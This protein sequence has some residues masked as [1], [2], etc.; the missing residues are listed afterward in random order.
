MT[1]KL[2]AAS[3]DAKA[4][5]RLARRVRARVEAADGLHDSEFLNNN[6]N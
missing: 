6:R 4:K 3:G 5:E 2:L 1:M